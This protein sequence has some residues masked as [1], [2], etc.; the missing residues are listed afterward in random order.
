MRGFAFNEAI[1]SPDGSAA[2]KE[3]TVVGSNHRVRI[4][5]ACREDGKTILLVPISVVRAIPGQDHPQV[6]RPVVPNLVFDGREYEVHRHDGLTGDVVF[7]PA[8]LPPTAESYPVGGDKPECTGPN[9]DARVCPVHQP[10][11]NQPQVPGTNNIP[12]AGGSV[13]QEAETAQYSG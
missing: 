12:D 8:T 13:P 9:S 3:A 4:R 6:C 10:S 5:T 2:P 7:H 11:G 1:S